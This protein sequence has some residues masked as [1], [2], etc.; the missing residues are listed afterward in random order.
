[1]RVRREELEPIVNPRDVSRA[2]QNIITC[3]RNQMSHFEG[4]KAKKAILLKVM[5]DPLCREILPEEITNLGKASQEVVSGLVQSLSEVKSINSNTN[6]ATRHAIFTAVVSSGAS[7]V[8]QREKARLLQVHPRNLAMASKRRMALEAADE[9]AWVLS[10]RKKRKDRMCDSWK[11]AAIAWWVSECRMS[12]NRK[13]VVRGLVS[14]G[15]YEKRP[16][17][18][19]LESTVSSTASY[20]CYSLLS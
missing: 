13:E 11:V 14:P 8:S 1:V 6:L 3:A 20:M 16:A 5:S 19:L 7:S 15:V 18:Y 12:P 17:Q 10:I 2:A 9:F 4:P